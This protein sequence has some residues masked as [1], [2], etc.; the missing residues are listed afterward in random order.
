MKNVNRN[1]FR[2]EQR[3]K[4][5]TRWWKLISTRTLEEARGEVAFYKSPECRSALLQTLEYRIR[6]KEAS[7]YQEYP[8]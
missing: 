1:W 4:G 5:A 2:I 6:R 3:E 8:T 7:G